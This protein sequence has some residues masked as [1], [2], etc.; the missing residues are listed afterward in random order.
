MIENYA[1]GVAQD[2][3]KAHQM[4][5]SEENN[6]IT[7]VARGQHRPPTTTAFQLRCN[8]ISHDVAT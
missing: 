2:T 6:E 7:L 1:N 3:V 5:I 4:L 8:S